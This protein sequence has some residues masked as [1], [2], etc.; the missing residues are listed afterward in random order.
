M[1]TEKNNDNGWSTSRYVAAALFVAVSAIGLYYYLFINPGIRVPLPDYPDRLGQSVLIVAPHNDDEALASGGVIQKHLAGGATVKVVLVTNGDGQFRR[2]FMKPKEYTSLG[3]RRQRETIAAMK[4]VGLKESDIY[5]LSYPDQGMNRMWDEYWD[6]KKLFR[7]K[8]TGQDHSIYEKSFTPGAPYCGMAVVRDLRQIILENKPKMIIAPHPNDLHPDHWAVN[9]FVVYTLEKLKKEKIGNEA[10]AKTELLTYVVHFGRWPMP[11]GNFKKASLDPPKALIKLDT[12]W[13]RED[14]TPEMTLRKFETIKLY[15][16]Q[17][18]IMT[19]Y[20]E[21]FARRNELFGVVPDLVLQGSSSLVRGNQME[22]GDEV[23]GDG[24][25]TEEEN[26]GLTY[27]DPR[28]IGFISEIRR[29]NN[30]RS[31]TI[32]KDGGM[33]LFIVELRDKMKN[34]NQMMIHIKPIPN[35]TGRESV[36]FLYSAGSLFLNGA[37][38][39]KDQRYSYGLE[40]PDVFTLSVPKDELTSSGEMIVGV[41]L[42]NN[43]INF[44]KAAYRLVKFE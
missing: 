18:E 32:R 31:V 11:R 17:F 40:K 4:H 15:P 5:F 43:G 10:L 33:I 8:H 1:N 2:P 39:S 44:D 21:S 3:E 30:I 12:K 9:A 25:M 42:I 14:L 13:M 16:S 28:H 26:L 7:S 23:A 20:L 24:K 41:E 6:C 29:Y 27:M 22:L 36:V 35:G 34:S 38:V 19:R 37:N